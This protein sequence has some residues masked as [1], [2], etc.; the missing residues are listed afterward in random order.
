MISTQVSE[1]D[2]DHVDGRLTQT[3]V[4]TNISWPTY[5]AML[6]DM[7]EHR[8][9]RLAFDQG[10]MTEDLGLEGVDMGSMTLEREDLE[11]GAE[12]DTGFYIQNAAQLEGL[13]PQIPEGLPPD[14]VI[15]VDITS[16]S[17]QRMAIY[18][19]LE[20]PEM[21]RYTKRRGLVI[22]QLQAGQYAETETSVAFQQVSVAQLNE[23]LL[24]R[25]RQGENQVIRAVR[26]WIQEEES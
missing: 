17:A 21:W 25:Q 26:N 9:A 2:I 23:F 11:K 8:A 15:E 22:Y 3:V 1:L 16:P 18:E 10:T 6:A 12:P 24:A 4:L 5:Q 13:D 14:L 19:A 20:V 7:G